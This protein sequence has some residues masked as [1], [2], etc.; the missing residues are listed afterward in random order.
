M[1]ITKIFSSLAVAGLIG[2]TAFG[3]ANAATTTDV[4]AATNTRAMWSWYDT[5]V[6]TVTKQN[7]MLDFAVARKVN[8]I[9]LQSETLLGKPALLAAFLDRAAAR[10]IKVE[11]LFGAANWVLP[12]NHAYVVNL[13][14]RTNTFVASLKG[15]RPVG[16][17][18]DIEPHGLPAWNTDPVTL[19]NQLVDLYGKL[20]A[21]KAPGLTVNADIA[22]GYEYVSLTRS[23]VTK[24]MSQWMVDATD[25]TTLMDYRDYGLGVDSIES[26][27]M[28][29]ISYALSRGKH[30]TL[31]VETTCNQELEKITF[32]EEGRARMETEL[33]MV[34]SYFQGNAGFGGFAIHDY[35]NYRKLAN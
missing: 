15:A 2:F 16:M 23:G 26:H 8:R 14:K 24:T 18:F 27:G 6:A 1:R 5:D 33:S 35:A 4:L 10:G 22:M 34:R 9:Y 32:C 3:S 30:S 21:A 11:L 13:V 25:S 31:G 20:M 28:H 19:G 7:T 12:V 17:H 29:P